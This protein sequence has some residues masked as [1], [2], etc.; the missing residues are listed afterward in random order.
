MKAASTETGRH[1]HR[2]V[3]AVLL[4]KLKPVRVGRYCTV[5]MRHQSCVSMGV[6]VCVRMAASSAQEKGVVKDPT[7]WPMS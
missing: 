6:K 5:M 7:L 2:H 4:T 3:F 1:Q